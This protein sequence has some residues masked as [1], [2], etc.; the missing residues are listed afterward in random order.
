MG[1]TS[2]H[3]LIIVIDFSV[4]LSPSFSLVSLFLHMLDRRF[5]RPPHRHHL[6]IPSFLLFV[7]LPPI[8]HLLSDACQLELSHVATLVALSMA[9]PQEMALTTMTSCVS[10]ATK[11]TPWKDPPQP[12]AR[13]TASGAISHQHAEVW[14]GYQAP[15]EWINDW[16][17]C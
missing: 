11:A 7:L 2:C 3:L 15:A 4:S 1:V 17:L 10:P 5:L 16:Q 6:C 14:S 9:A 8:S 12:S 13:P